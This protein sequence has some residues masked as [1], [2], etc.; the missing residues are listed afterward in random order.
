MQKNR[1][2]DCSDPSDLVS[3]SG[4]ILCLGIYMPTKTG[5]RDL[6]RTQEYTIRFGL[7]MANLQL[8]LH[9]AVRSHDVHIPCYTLAKVPGSPPHLPASSL[10]GPQSDGLWDSAPHRSLL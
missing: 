5:G 3:R 4:K 9:L 2:G 8:G 6:K 10:Q 1:E 7:A